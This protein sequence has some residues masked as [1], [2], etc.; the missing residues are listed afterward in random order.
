MRKT[1]LVVVALV[2]I[3]LLAEPLKAGQGGNAPAS[4]GPTSGKG[5]TAV[6]QTGKG[7]S[8][9]A[10]DAVKVDPKHYYKVDVENDQVRVIHFHLG[11]REICPMHS[12]PPNLLIA[13]TDGHVKVT[14]KDGKARDIMRKAGGVTYRPAEI[15]TVENLG[16]KDYE[17]VVVELKQSPA[18]S[19][20]SKSK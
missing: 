17:S 3:Y 14:G 19:E 16:D 10:L 9:D 8:V 18:R 15:H 20:G 12:H 11:P 5:T 4:S 2:A 1:S 6:E 7:D 13:L